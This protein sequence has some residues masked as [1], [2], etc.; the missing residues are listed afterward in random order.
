MASNTKNTNK[1]EKQQKNN[2]EK[3]QQQNP[4]AASGKGK[5]KQQ[6]QEEQTP[7]LNPS[8][9]LELRSQT[10]LNLKTDKTRNPYPHKFEVSICIPDF[11]QKYDYLSPNQQLD[12]TL[13]NV[14]GR[15]TFIRASSNKL[16][17]YAI[18]GN[19]Q[20]LQ[21]LSNFQFYEDKEDYPKITELLRRGDV[22]GIIGYPARSKTGELS[23]VPKKIE[24]L[25]PCLHNLPFPGGL[26]DI[27]TRYRSRYL[28]L[29]LHDEVTETFVKRCKIIKFIRRFFDDRGF[30]EVETPTMSMLAGGATAKPFVTYHNDLG[31]NLFLRI[32]TELY[33]KQLIVGGIDKVYEIGKNFRNEGIDL[34]HNPEFTAIEFYWAYADYYDLIELT[35]NLLSSLVYHLYGTYTIKFYPQGKDFPENVK[36]INFQPPYDRIPMI[37]TLEKELKISFPQPLESTECHE[38]LKKLLADKKIECTPPLTTAR[39]LDKLVG[40]Y[41]EPLLVNPSFIIDHPQLMSPLAKY[42]RSKPGVTERFELFVCG[43]ELCNA[44]T[45]LNDPFVQRQLF[46]DQAKDRDAGDDE[47]QPI[48]EG[49]IEALEHGLPPTA[50]W[51]MGIDR[52][53]MFLTNHN[54]IKE[55]VLFPALRPLERD[56]QAQQQQLSMVDIK[57]IPHN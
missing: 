50:G 19:Q 49:F 30:L 6:K 10:V 56:R 28:D 7:E 33:L 35:E 9:Y 55:V 26:K 41:I 2:P 53:V 1:K 39:M 40:E 21:V 29:I 25:A 34:T 23:I 3:K 16:N 37:E 17:F 36:E 38:F 15:I 45:E 44:Y 20:K 8:Q 4:Q 47:A 32:A 31:I 11:R 5:G 22:I 52:L 42:H 14:S 18:S 54:S 48:D 51:G 12:D 24:L 27:E 46:K 43:K 13:E 57:N